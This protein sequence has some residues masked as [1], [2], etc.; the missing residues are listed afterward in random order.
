M[1]RSTW[2][3]VEMFSVRTPSGA[4]PV[5]ILANGNMQAEIIV[6]IKVV[7][8][9]GYPVKL[10][11]FDKNKLNLI[12]YNNAARFSYD[13]SISEIE[14]IYTHT[15]ADNTLTTTP[16]PL[17][18]VQS[19]RFWVTTVVETPV[20]IGAMIL[21]PDEST[22]S[23]HSTEFDSHI[24]CLGIAP[25]RYKLADVSFTQQ[26]T[27][28]SPKYPDG[29]T[30]DQDNYYLSLKNG[31]PI[32]AVEWRYGSM[33]IF[34]QRN[35]SASTQQLYA[36]PL[37]ANKTQTISVQSATAID[38]YD[39]TVNNYPGQVTFTRISAALTDNPLSDT[40]DN[41]LTFRILDN[42]GNYGD[43]TVSQTNS[44]NTMK[45]VDYPA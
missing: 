22:V 26:N 2:S 37:D 29:V 1:S 23:T 20:S 4:T 14:N 7:D 17:S 9:N 16:G 39:I 28:D 19:F 41:P 44:F 31:N 42:L 10:T 13:W 35:T 36:W 8:E 34:A 43:F 45:I 30:I 3:K 33:N 12:D 11:E 32:V 25:S 18:D 5:E 21:L 24:Q 15:L 27:S 40:F 6:D 38:N